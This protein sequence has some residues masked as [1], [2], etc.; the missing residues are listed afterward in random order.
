MG[1]SNQ[2]QDAKNIINIL[3]INS[4]LLSDAS[5]RDDILFILQKKSQNQAGDNLKE[6]NQ[7]VDV[8]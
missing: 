8:I 6:R 4:D 3:E 1:K 5:H 2:Q 7:K